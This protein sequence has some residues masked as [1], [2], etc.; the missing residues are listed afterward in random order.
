MLDRVRALS[1]PEGEY[2]VIGSGVMDALGLRESQDVDLVVSSQLFIELR[3][4]GWKKFIEHDQQ[5][6]KYSDAEAWTT[7]S[8]NGKDLELIELLDHTM[9]IEDIN[10][11]SPQFLKNWKTEKSR[12]KDLADIELLKEYLS[13]DK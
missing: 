13:H 1:L 8:Y 9:Q 5:V 7:W 10:F 4:R 11:I 12:P 2:I 6:L 3:S